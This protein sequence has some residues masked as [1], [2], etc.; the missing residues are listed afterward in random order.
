VNRRTERLPTR[1]RGTRDQRYRAPGGKWYAVDAALVP[2]VLDRL[3]ALPDLIVE[4]TC[5]GHRRGGERHAK[6]VFLA[7]VSTF[8]KA[9]KS[10]GD[11]T[12]DVVGDDALKHL[13]LLLAS[14][15]CDLFLFAPFLDR[16]SASEYRAR[17]SRYRS[18]GGPLRWRME[19]RWDEVG[20]APLN[21]WAGLVDLLEENPD[22]RLWMGDV[23]RR[24]RQHV[25][26][27]E[28]GA[29]RRRQID[30]WINGWQR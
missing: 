28:R 2:A 8:R 27:T 17:V 6:V 29:E 18:N 12:G 19:I 11:S 13:D 15:Y 22:C 5:A 14:P 23:E 7:D 1:H 4:E 24:R 25:R 16:L 3:N 10:L 21:W 9:R 26:Q 30:A 20:E